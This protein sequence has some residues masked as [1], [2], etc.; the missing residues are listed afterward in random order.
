MPSLIADQIVIMDNA[1]FHPKK[2]I[3]KLIAQAGC[4]VIFLPSY[5]P[6]LN[7]IEKFW[8][9]LK[10]HLSKIILNYSSLVEALNQAFVDLS[11][12]NSKTEL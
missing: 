2:R 8:A 9:R 6:E 4:K 7:K 5:S 11:W 3:K 12:I 10:K 1:S